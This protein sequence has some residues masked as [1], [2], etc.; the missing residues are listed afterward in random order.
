MGRLNSSCPLGRSEGQTVSMRKIKPSEIM[1]KGA[2]VYA[3]VSVA[4]SKISKRFDVIPSGTLYPNADEIEYLRRLV[5][6]KDSAILVLNKPPKLPVKGKVPVHNSMDAL[7]AAALSYDYD[8]GPKLV[9]RLD[10]ESSGL[11]LMGRTKESISHLHWLF[12]DVRKANPWSKVVDTLL[13]YKNH[14][15]RSRL[16]VLQRPFLWSV[17]AQE[18]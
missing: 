6:Y 13:A 17:F 12:S 9:H 7:A 1:E 3:P 18:V 14:P 5:K 8:E 11:L 2:R 10:R 4:E 15:Y 16:Q